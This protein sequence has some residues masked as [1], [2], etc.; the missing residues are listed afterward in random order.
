MDSSVSE[1]LLNENW[2]FEEGKVSL[3]A[4]RGEYVSFQLVVTN[5]LGSTLEYIKIKM[6][7]FENGG[8]KIPVEPELFLEW[9]VQVKTPSTGYPKSSL[10]KGWYPDALIP[11]KYIQDDSAKVHRIWTYPLWLP[12]FN[13][14]IDMQKSM[15]IWVDQYIPFQQNIAKA[16]QYSTSIS[17][18]IG[19]FFKPNSLFTTSKI[20]LFK[21]FFSFSE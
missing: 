20:I 4:A 14:R 7:P 15:I 8:S 17:V 1:E 9:S 10:G 12:D 18:T 13:N 6:P 19:T 2:I 3:H 5:Y 21:S 11:F 16:G